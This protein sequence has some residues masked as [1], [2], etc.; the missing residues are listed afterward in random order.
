[1][2]QNEAGEEQ[3][4]MMMMKKKKKKTPSQHQKEK[5]SDVLNGAIKTSKNRD[6][7]S[8]YAEDTIKASKEK[9]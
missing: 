4:K 9:D 5:D 7:S 3:Q 2:T 6:P 8:K 1:M